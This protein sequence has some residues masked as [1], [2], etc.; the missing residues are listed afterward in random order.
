MFHDDHSV[1]IKKGLIFTF[2]SLQ[3]METYSV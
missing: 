2:E 3:P 1:R